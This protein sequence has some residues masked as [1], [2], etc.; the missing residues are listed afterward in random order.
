MLII[1][2]A[3]FADIPAIVELAVESV[4]RNPWPLRIDKQAMESTAREL[5]AGNQHFAEV[6]EDEGK[7]VGAVG[8]C[9]QPGF[10]HERMTCSVLMFFAKKA[11]AGVALLRSFARWVRGRPAIKMAIFSLEADLDPRIGLL[12][13]RL[14]F[15]HQAPCYTYIRGMST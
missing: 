5:I 10:W 6:A 8:A 3:K 14:G 15:T 4:S 12:L 2:R 11:G 9:T 1:R 13:H 7:I